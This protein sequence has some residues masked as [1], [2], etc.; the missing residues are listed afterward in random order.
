MKWLTTQDPEMKLEYSKKELQ[1][2]NTECGMFCL[3]II[4]RLIEGDEFVEITRRN[5]AD[6]DMLD[7]RDWL[8]ST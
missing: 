1:K 5:P 3:Y 7:Y 6:S 4:S 8:F 2:S